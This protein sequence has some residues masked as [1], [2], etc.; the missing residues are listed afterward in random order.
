MAFLS[1]PDS[2]KCGGLAII[3]VRL[4]DCA[5][6]NAPFASA[7]AQYCI[8]KRPPPFPTFTRHP[9]VGLPARGKSY[10][11]KKLS[12]YL[13][14]LGYETNVFN[15]GE[16]RRKTPGFEIADHSF[17]SSGDAD[18]RRMREQIAFSVLDVRRI[19]FS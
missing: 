17:F 11:V 1:D 9:Q 16:A 19:M 6:Q 5:F 14:W 15:V 4:F 10:M 12:R 7:L 2:Q 18:A 13:T 8:S 3:L